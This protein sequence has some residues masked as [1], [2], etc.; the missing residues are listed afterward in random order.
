MKT[1]IAG[2]R[3]IKDRKLVERAI[4]ESGFKITRIASGTATGVDKLGE[5]WA[6]RKGIEV[7][8]FPPKWIKY[9]KG[10]GPIRNQEMAD[11]ADALIL[12]FDGQSKG[13]LSMLSIARE[14]GLKI[15]VLNTGDKNGTA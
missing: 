13:S 8:L 14:A 7:N 10:A 1:I 4:K 12:I 9:G 6:A 11:W 3:S 15:H 2:S 5:Q